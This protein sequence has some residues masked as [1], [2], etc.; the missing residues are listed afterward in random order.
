MS[1]IGKK[2]ITIPNNIKLTRN[3]DTMIIEGPMG[4]LN[5][6]IP[7]NIEVK[8]VNNSLEVTTKSNMDDSSLQ[9]LYR[10]LIQNAV[11]GV[12]NKWRKTVELSG[13]GYTAA[14]T[15]NKLTLNLGFSHP[16]EINAPEGI[17][18][19]V[20]ENKIITQGANKYL[21]GEVAAKIRKIRPPEPYKGKGIRYVG[22]YIRKKLGKAAKAVGGTTAK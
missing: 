18:F 20:K 15:G 6:V 12:V 22:E 13:V 19:E 11:L 21:V 3:R 5:I 14:T 7:E 17:T 9:G 8:T 2:P 16:V 4:K 10:T 1:R